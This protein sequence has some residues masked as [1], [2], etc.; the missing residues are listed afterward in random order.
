MRDQHGELLIMVK[1]HFA[2]VI[3]IS[4]AALATGG[5]LVAPAARAGA[6]E[7]VGGSQVTVAVDAGQP[8]PPVNEGL[9]GTNQPVPGAGPAVSALGVDWARADFSLDASYDCATGSWNPAIADQ[10]VQEDLAMGG[11]PE[12]IVDY[13]PPCLTSNPL[14]ET[15]DPPDADGYLPW[16]A[17]VQQA[18][19]HEMTTYGVHIFEVWNEPDGT[20]WHGS[21]ADY[22]ATYK[23][24]AEAIEAAANQAHMSDVLIGGPAL[25]FSDSAWLEPFLAYV[26]LNQLPLGFVSWHYYGNYPALGPFA[27]GA[28]VI[29][30]QLPGLGDYWYNPAT[31]AQTF[32]VQVAQVR[33]EIAKYPALHPLT[34][35]DEWNLDA[36]YDPRADGPYDAAF[37]AAV[38]DASQGAGLDRMAFFRV[39]DDKPGTLGNW[40]MLHADFSPKPVYWAF[41]FWHQLDGRVLPTSESPDQTGAAPTGQIGAVAS[42]GMGGTPNVLVYNYASFDPTGGYGSTDPNAYD[43]PVTV[44]IAGLDHGRWDYTVK[45]VD[46]DAQGQVVRTGTL[47]PSQRSLALVMPGESVALVQLTR[48]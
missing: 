14:H 40:G 21:I 36:G 4:L 38:L 20:F 23:A 35:I 26:S 29:P 18:A 41:S 8:G 6:P 12:M 43:H 27:T 2:R 33:A 34:V 39:A 13:S 11:Q 24:T 46:A 42:D 22:L 5:G 48:P 3:A 17:L 47:K 28:G 16:K 31:L 7:A 44:N 25:L 30:P 9:L 19:Y 1:S 45:M 10:R 37:A 15:L 32:G